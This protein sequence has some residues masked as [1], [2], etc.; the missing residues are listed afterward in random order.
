MVGIVI[1]S[2]SEQLALG[3]K[4]LA[5]QM[6]NDVPIAAA[7]GTTD[8]RMGTDMD[9]IISSIKEVYSEDGVIVL[10]DLGSAYMNAEM[11]L[12]FL[13][14]DLRKNVLI[15]DAAIVEGTVIAAIESGMNKSMI[16]IKDELKDL[17]IG[18][19]PE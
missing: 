14:Y 16:E 5:V 18:K 2:H 6:A 9:K 12:E 17:R 3:V 11:S 13:E 1:V 4:E 7:G 15:V 19:M 8:G 10:F